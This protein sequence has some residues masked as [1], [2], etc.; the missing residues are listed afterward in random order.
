MEHASLDKWEKEELDDRQIVRL[1]QS[2]DEKAVDCLIDRYLSMVQTQAKTLC[3]QGMEWEDLLQEGLIGL[4]QAVVRYDPSRESS[5]KTFASHCSQNRMLSAIE[6]QGREKRSP[7][8]PNVS[9]EQDPI[10]GGADHGSPEEIVIRQESLSHRRQQLSQLLTPF[11][12]QVLSQYLKGYSYQ[13]IGKHINASSKGVDN[14]LQRIR[15][16]LRSLSW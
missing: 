14:A 7:K 9:L 5:F 3:P 1:A 15:R 11:E 2:G 12:R 6:R 13:E 8:L 16:K 4:F 10:P